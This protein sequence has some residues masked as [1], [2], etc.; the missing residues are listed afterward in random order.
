MNKLIAKQDGAVAIV[1]ALL[2]VV[3]LVFGAFAVDFGYLYVVK[4][5]VQNSADAAAL[6]GATIYYR[7]SVST[8]N[9]AASGGPQTITANCT[10]SSLTEQAACTAAAALPL[11]E[12]AAYTF[13][14]KADIGNNLTPAVPAFPAVQVDVTRTSVPFFLAR[15]IGFTT[16]TISASATAIARNSTSPANAP[17]LPI[18]FNQCVFRNPG[19]PFSGPWNDLTGWTLSFGMPYPDPTCD[20]MQWTVLGYREHSPGASEIAELLDNIVNSGSSNQVAPAEGAPNSTTCDPP[21]VDGIDTCIFLKPGVNQSLFSHLSP[22]VGKLFSV[23]VVYRAP[24]GNGGNEPVEKIACVELT[25]ICV[26]SGQIQ[27]Q[28]GGYKGIYTGGQANS[29]EPTG[30]Q[31]SS[32][33]GSHAYVSLTIHPDADC[34]GSGTGWTHGIPSPPKLA[35]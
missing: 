25:N 11:N 24:G 23:P 27:D 21:G 32:C 1:V 26:S 4:N 28:A 2:L 10:G 9:F 22:Y 5:Q 31:P 33:P 7:N 29:T 15:A 20:A 18:A 19:T 6:A 34:S 17:L 14:V 35:N 30:G 16:R 8:D 12:P 13:Q 3:L